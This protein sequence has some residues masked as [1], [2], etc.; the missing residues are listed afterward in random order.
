MFDDTI[1]KKWKAESISTPDTDVTTAM[2]DF[3]IDELRW[4]A[5]IFK[6]TGAVVVFNG[7]VVKSDNTVPGDL[8]EA[9][10]AGVK[11]L[12]DVPDKKKDY[13]P[14]SNDQVLDLVHPS[15]FPLIYGRSRILKDRTIGIEDAIDNIG[16]D[17]TI[18]SQDNFK[19]DQ[20]GVSSWNRRAHEQSPYSKNY[21][22]LPCEVEVKDRK[23][24]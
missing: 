5:G 7:D 9:L 19:Q 20:T 8:K 11:A 1:A 2:M 22:W 3:V 14:G 4:K 17:E 10:K 16:K 21:Q 24:R 6:R 15:L 23:A 12:E 13:H 18:P